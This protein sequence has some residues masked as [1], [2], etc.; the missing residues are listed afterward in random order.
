MPAIP[1]PTE[2]NFEDRYPD[3][4]AVPELFFGQHDTVL[5]PNGNFLVVN[6]TN[7]QIDIYDPR[8]HLPPHYKTYMLGMY[9]DPEGTMDGTIRSRYPSYPACK[10]PDIRPLE[11][12]GQ[13][14]DLF[15]TTARPIQTFSA[16]W[17]ANSPALNTNAKVYL[18]YMRNP[19]NQ[20]LPM[21]TLIEA[22]V[23]QTPTSKILTNLGFVANLDT[24]RHL[25]GDTIKLNFDRLP[26]SS[27]DTPTTS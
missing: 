26:I 12:L 15:D 25:N 20:H 2:K 27:R 3:Q 17:H 10:H 23:A 1:S 8:F 6:V 5:T 14:I 22:A 13:I 18:G 4:L 19:A 9:V 21:D 11:Q 16:A 24:F 7:S